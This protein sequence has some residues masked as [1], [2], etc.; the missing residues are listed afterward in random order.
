MSSDRN[1]RIQEMMDQ[2]ALLL[3]VKE[4]H[5][6]L[7]KRQR[8]KY[9]FVKRTLQ[10]FRI[11]FNKSGSLSSAAAQNRIVVP[12]YSFN[13]AEHAYKLRNPSPLP[14]LAR[15]LFVWQ[16]LKQWDI[17]LRGYDKFFNSKQRE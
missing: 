9:E 5:A 4:E 11:P 3:T 14:H 13:C 17:C 10:E 7:S 6:H 2:Y 15:G 8:Q 16:R 12:V 1:E